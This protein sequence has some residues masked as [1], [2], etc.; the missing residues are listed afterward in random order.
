[1][2]SKVTEPEVGVMR[3]R[4]RRPVVDLPQP[5]SPTTPEGLALAELQR[6]AG[7]RGDVPDGAAEH[8]RPDVA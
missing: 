7:H 3:W 4:S 8:A 6:D 2:P 1:M 5:D